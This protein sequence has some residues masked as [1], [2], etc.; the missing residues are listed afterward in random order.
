M[1]KIL[2]V[3]DHAPTR[4]MFSQ[5]LAQQDRA[6]RQAYGLDCATWDDEWQAYV[7][8]TYPSK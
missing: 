4:L 3:D 2:L 1:K 8:K 6:L 7:R 5:I